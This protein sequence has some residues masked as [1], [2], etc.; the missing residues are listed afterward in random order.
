MDVFLIQDC[1]IEAIWSSE[2]LAI[3][4]PKLLE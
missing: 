2:Q 4:F 3:R 1:A